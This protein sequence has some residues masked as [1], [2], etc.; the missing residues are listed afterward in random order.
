M[1]PT[2]TQ[3]PRA[4]AEDPGVSGFRPVIA[5]VPARVS[6]PADMEALLTCLVTLQQTAPHARAVV[7]D[8]ASP[9]AELVDQLEAIIGQL[10]AELIR[11]PAGGTPA[12]AVN[13]GLRRAVESGADAVLLDPSV[14]LAH[15]GWLQA[16]QARTDTQGRPAAVV[17]ALLV[18]PNGLVE[19]AGF[20]FS[21]LMRA[22]GPRLRYAPAGL[23]EAQQAARCPV[24]RGLVLIRHET[25]L[26]VGLYDEEYGL[27]SDD[28]D[29]CLRAFAAGLECIYEPAAR[30][31][32][33]QPLKPGERDDA[34]KRLRNASLERLMNLHRTLDLGPFVPAFG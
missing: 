8:D 20:F 28:V 26:E 34:E 31:I 7:V 17:G 22:F 10:G 9:A 25:L 23:P 29:Y 3:A 15:A 2:A 4:C 33:H 6:T 16:L 11:R 18:Y 1:D 27:G 24:G 5:V 30:A 21:L 13:A 12:A 14:E 32:R 19:H